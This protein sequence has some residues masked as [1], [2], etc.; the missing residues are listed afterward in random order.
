MSL[1]TSPV[2]LADSTPADHIFNIRNDLTNLKANQFGRVWIESAAAAAVAS[3]MT[4]KHDES[5]PSIRRRLLQYKYNALL[6]DGV[7]YKPITANFSVICNPEH[8][9][10]Q[11]EVAVSIIE[12]ALGVA[13]F[14][15]AF[16]EGQM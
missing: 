10:A 1:F 16:N 5:S 8:T 2:T 13:G 14:V 6:P 15:A 11:V 7:T 9:D 4:V 3:F 12:A